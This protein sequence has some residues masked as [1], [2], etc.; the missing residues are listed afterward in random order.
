MTEQ[1]QIEVYRLYPV[2]RRC[3]ASVEATRI[4]NSYF[5]CDEWHVFFYYNA[6]SYLSCRNV[7]VYVVFFLQ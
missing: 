2:L 6:Y 5:I 7:N 4:I 3:Y 1:P